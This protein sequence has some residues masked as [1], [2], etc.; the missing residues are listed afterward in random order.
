MAT[1]VIGIGLGSN[2]FDIIQFKFLLKIISKPII[3]IGLGEKQR[4][5]LCFDNC[6]IYNAIEKHDK[7]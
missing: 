1:L 4:S 5:H 3:S 6:I 2:I 7:T